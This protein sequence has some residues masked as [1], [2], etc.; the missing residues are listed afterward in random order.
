MKAPLPPV[1][2]SPKREL[3]GPSLGETAGLQNI[4]KLESLYGKEM[5]VKRSSETGV[6]IMR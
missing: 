3:G 5:A 4:S 1:T 2:M 6:S